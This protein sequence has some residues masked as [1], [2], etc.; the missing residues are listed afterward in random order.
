MVFSLFTVSI[1][2][3]LPW[4]GLLRALPSPKNQLYI[5]NFNTFS[6]TRPVLDLKMSLDRARQDLKFCV[7][8]IGPYQLYIELKYLFND[9]TSFRT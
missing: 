5:L 9:K 3:I 7:T 1:A 2:S 6:V 4:G 8:P